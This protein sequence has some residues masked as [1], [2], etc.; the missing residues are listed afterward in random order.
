MTKGLQ[1]VLRMMQ[2]K[3]PEAPIVLMGIFPRNDSMEVMPA[4]DRVNANL[5]RIADGKKIR[6]LNINNRLADTNGRLFEGMMNPD[7]LHPTA[8]AYQIW[9]DALR[10]VLTELLGPPATED[11]A[12]PPTGDPSAKR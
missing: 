12:P 8:R 7:Q 4:I 1:A 2:S 5:A 6:Y 11:H 9:A 10:P 3:A